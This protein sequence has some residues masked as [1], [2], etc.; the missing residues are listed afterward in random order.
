[1]SGRHKFSELEATMTP[2]RRARVHEIAKK[3][4]ADVA[5]ATK[6][7]PGKAS[8]PDLA[9]APANPRRNVARS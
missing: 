1:M 9:D 5:R 3:L 4:D 7:L 2:A 8:D 6:R